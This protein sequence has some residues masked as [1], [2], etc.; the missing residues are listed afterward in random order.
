[1]A[2]RRCL[3]CTRSN[4]T[5]CLANDDNS[6]RILYILLN[7]FL[8]VDTLADII[9]I[10]QV[11][12]YRKYPY[13]RRR[14]SS[15]YPGPSHLSPAT[16]LLNPDKPPKRPPPVSTLKARLLLD[17]ASYRT[18]LINSSAVI[19]VVVSGILGFYLS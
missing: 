18:V 12:Y 16:P 10:A 7:I 11:L 5:A 3:Q 1:M 4:I 2:R 13:R 9:L 8:T 17:N 19:A 15:H 6:C 14:R